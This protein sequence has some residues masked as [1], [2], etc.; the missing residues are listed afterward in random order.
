MISSW[1]IDIPLYRSDVPCFQQSAN[2]LAHILFAKTNRGH[3]ISVSQKMQY[4]MM[5]AKDIIK[6]PEPVSNTLQGRLTSFEPDA[7]PL[8]VGR[9]AANTLEKHEGSYSIT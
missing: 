2:S 5:F 8:R 3:T 6:F 7:L 4:M 1:Q 9:M